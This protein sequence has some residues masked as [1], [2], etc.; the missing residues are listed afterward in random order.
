[1]SGVAAGR[2]IHINGRSVPCGSKLVRPAMTAAS[3]A[4]ACARWWSRWSGRLSA[5]RSSRRA[6]RCA[7]TRWSS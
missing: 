4:C 3:R 7:P 1:M 5:S 6:C 2:W